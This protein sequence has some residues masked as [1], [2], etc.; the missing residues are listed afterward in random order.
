MRQLTIV[1][2]L[3]M[4]GLTGCLGLSPFGS[5]I[6]YPEGY[7]ETGITDPELAAEQHNEALSEHDS[8]TKITNLTSP[9]GDGYA[10]ATIRTNNTNNHTGAT[11]KSRRSGKDTLKTEMYHNGDIG[12]TKSETDGYGNT[13]TTYEAPLS[14]TRKS[15]VN[16]SEFDKWFANISFEATGTVTRNGETLLRYNSTDIV[17]PKTFFHTVG[18]ST[19]DSIESVNSTLLIDEEGIIRQF[20]IMTTYRSDGKT[21]TGT[22]SYRITN[23]DSTSVEKPDWVETARKQAN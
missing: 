12:Y 23:V 18:F 3:I 16:P 4:V 5:D 22:I 6:S 13:Y 8:Y 20:T 14:S 7:N 1:C 19:M 10:A 2:L 11:V 17:D 9:S 21:Q 15:L